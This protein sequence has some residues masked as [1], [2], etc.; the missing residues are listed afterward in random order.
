MWGDE[1]E[2]ELKMLQGSRMNKELGHVTQR[3]VCSFYCSNLCRF[4]SHPHPHHRHPTPGSVVL[5]L[6]SFFFSSQLHMPKTNQPLSLF[7]VP[8]L[9]RTKERSALSLV[10]EAQVPEA[11]P[12]TENK[13][14]SVKP[15]LEL[16]VFIHQWN[17]LLA[18]CSWIFHTSS[19]YLCVQVWIAPLIY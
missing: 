19:I 13:R 1:T 3:F 6:F 9:I 16:R 11:L 10:L 17:G 14:S 5:F 2:Q 15:E 8:Q 18:A 7:L 12:A 4:Y